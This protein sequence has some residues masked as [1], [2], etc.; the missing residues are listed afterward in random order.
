MTVSF[1]IVN[2]ESA[3][4]IKARSTIKFG[5]MDAINLKNP[6][7]SMFLYRTKDKTTWNLRCS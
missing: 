3:S 4:D 5:S 1:Y 6:N 2:D 7:G